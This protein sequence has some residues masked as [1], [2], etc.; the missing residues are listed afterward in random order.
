[1][2]NNELIKVNNNIFTKIKNWIKRLKQKF[3]YRKDVKI[4]VEEIEAKH[5]NCNNEIIINAKNAYQNYVLNS[6]YT[7]GE[8][9]Y[10]TIRE[11]LNIN[12]DAIDKLIE[13]NKFNLILLLLLWYNI[14]T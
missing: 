1:M 9:I 6:D 12:K 14:N 4:D 5:N 8:N 7:L 2:K 13:I 11:R 10:K 3:T